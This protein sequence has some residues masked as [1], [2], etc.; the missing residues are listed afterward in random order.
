MQCKSTYFS[1]TKFSYDASINHTGSQLCRTLV[2]GESWISGSGPGIAQGQDGRRWSG[3]GK[4][5]DFGMGIEFSI[6]V[7]GPANQHE[8]AWLIP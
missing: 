3:P 6:L 1:E 2:S 7:V 8:E 5:A 4:A